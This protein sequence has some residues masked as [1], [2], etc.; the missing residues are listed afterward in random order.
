VSVA[1]LKLDWI[2][3]MVV[4][5]TEHRM[6]RRPDG[7]FTM[8]MCAGTILK[9]EHIEE[10]VKAVST[11]TEPAYIHFQALENGQ[12]NVSIETTYPAE[13]SIRVEKRKTQGDGDPWWMN[14]DM[15][16]KDA[17][18]PACRSVWSNEILSIPNYDRK[19]VMFVQRSSQNGQ[20]VIKFWKNMQLGMDMIKS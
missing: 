1:I 13:S 12:M 5:N 10:L 6:K 8:R 15:I 19:C 11:D 7:T 18:I 16:E 20:M 17:E 14:L 9:K 3:T 2:K 4:S